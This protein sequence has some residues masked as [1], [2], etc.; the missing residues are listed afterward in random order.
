[1][2]CS[3]TVSRREKSKSSLVGQAGSCCLFGNPA[4][5]CPV[6]AA[7]PG[8]LSSSCTGAQHRLSPTVPALQPHITTTYFFYF[9][10][11]PLPTTFF[12]GWFGFWLSHE[13]LVREDSA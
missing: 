6:P 12:S 4:P 9:L 3:I 5:L 1:M 11:F 10:F 7:S 13:Q 8:L 2:R